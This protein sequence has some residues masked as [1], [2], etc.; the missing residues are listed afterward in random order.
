MATVLSSDFVLAVGGISRHVNEGSEWA[1]STDVQLV[2]LEPKV[3]GARLKLAY[4]SLSPRRSTAA[5]W[6]R[7]YFPIGVSFC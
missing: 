6:L 2:S 7:R 3:V 5:H 1:T 4:S